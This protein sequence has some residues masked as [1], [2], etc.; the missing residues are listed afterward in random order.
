L[1]GYIQGKKIRSPISIKR[2]RSIRIKVNQIVTIILM[3]PRVDAVQM[4][5]SAL[6]SKARIWMLPTKVIR[7]RIRKTAR[8][9]T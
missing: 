3:T 5:V 9:M 6:A 2:A 4:R 7:L 8:G 1:D